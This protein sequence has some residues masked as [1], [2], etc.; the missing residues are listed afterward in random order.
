M[1]RQIRERFPQLKVMVGVFGFAGDAAKAKIRFE[2]TQPDRL[3]TSL[4]EAVA[5]VEELACPSPEA[6][7]LAACGQQ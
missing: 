6:A 1:C 7:S 5:H 4:A 2:R 3:S